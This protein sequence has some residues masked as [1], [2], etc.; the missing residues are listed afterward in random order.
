[1]KITNYEKR[2]YVLNNKKNLKILL[3]LRELFLCK[4]PTLVREKAK[5]IL[6]V[7]KNHTCRHSIHFSVWFLTIKKLEKEKLSE[8]D[9]EFL[10]LARTQLKRDWQTP[11]IIANNFNTHENF[12]K[13]SAPQNFWINF[14]GKK[15]FS[16]R[17]SENLKIFL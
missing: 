13:F 1:M 4:L 15:I 16:E 17:F 8:K 2:N 7:F 5:I 12:Q 14:D 9:R 6:E 11:L 10:T 3:I